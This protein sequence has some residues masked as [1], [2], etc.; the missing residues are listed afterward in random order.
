[1]EKELNGSKEFLYPDDNLLHRRRQ[2]ADYSAT[3]SEDDE[4]GP[5]EVGFYYVFWCFFNLRY[6][7][8]IFPNWQMKF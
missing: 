7:I 4:I 5:F 6:F 8:F 1:M 3:Q 2:S